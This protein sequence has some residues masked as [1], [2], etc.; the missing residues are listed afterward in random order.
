MI[1]ADYKII[2]IDK[3]GNAVRFYLTKDEVC[4]NEYWGDDWDDRPYEHNAGRVY[5]NYVDKVVDVFYHFDTFV[6]EA[7]DD[8]HYGG[9]SPY[10][11][12]DFKDRKAPCLIVYEKNEDEK[13]YHST[14]EYSFLLG[15]ERALKIYYGDSIKK[16]IATAAY[17][18]EGPDDSNM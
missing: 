4:L 15:D 3:C 1:D 16:A 9:N 12:E 7:S 6:T 5:G 13:Y 10:C 8:W 17:Y 11:K 2:D 18:E 14:P